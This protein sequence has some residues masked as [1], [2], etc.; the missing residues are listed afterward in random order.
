M[1]SQD[2]LLGLAHDPGGDLR[3]LLNVIA[4]ALRGDDR[5]FES[6][7]DQWR[8]RTGRSGSHFRLGF[9]FS[10]SLNEE[11]RCCAEPHTSDGRDSATHHRAGYRSAR[12]SLTWSQ[13]A[14]LV[15]FVPAARVRAALGAPLLRSS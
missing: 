8:T 11:G 13:L 3:L 9:N 12:L 2:L 1:T 14:A 6:R 15:V 4:Q 5:F 10:R 7:G